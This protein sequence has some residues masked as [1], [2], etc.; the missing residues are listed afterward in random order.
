VLIR[1]TLSGDYRIAT[2]AHE[3]QHVVEALSAHA[4]TSDEM[5]AVFAALDGSEPRGRRQFE[6]AAA[7][8]VTTQVLEELR[9]SRR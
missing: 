5:F 7:E 8:K 1:A 6:T 9:G 3:L 2:L 4:T